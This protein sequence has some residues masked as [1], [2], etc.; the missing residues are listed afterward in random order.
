MSDNDERVLKV[1]V[2]TSSRRD[3]SSRNKTTT[4]TKKKEIIVD[5]PRDLDICCGRG[6]GFFSHPGNILFQESVRQNVERYRSAASKNLKSTVVAD[7][8]KDLLREGL[9]FIKRDLESGSWFV[10]SQACCHEKTGHAIRDHLIQMKRSAESAAMRATFEAPAVTTRS[11]KNHSSSSTS[12]ISPK[13]TATKKNGSGGDSKKAKHRIK[14][15]TTSG[16]SAKKADARKTARDSITRET[17]NQSSPELPETTVVSSF[18]LGLDVVSL[19][20]SSDDL[21]EYDLFD[22]LIHEEPPQLL[23]VELKSISSTSNNGLLTQTISSAGSRH[24]HH[25]YS[26][27]DVFPQHL[28]NDPFFCVSTQ[29]QEHHGGRR[30]QH[31]APGGMAST[32]MVDASAEHEMLNGFLTDVPDRSHFEM[33]P[34]VTVDRSVCQ[35]ERQERQHQ[36]IHLDSLGGRD[37]S[38]SLSIPFESQGDDFFGSASTQAYNN[39]IGHRDYRVCSDSTNN[40]AASLLPHDWL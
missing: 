14:K 28:Q 34:C 38:L 36:G 23:P 26:I 20:S 39:F 1:L 16:G 31:Q 9:R 7:I 30:R 21:Q 2:S 33:N 5:T 29:L 12:K 25:N 24:Q 27:Q 8:V 19:T 32:A 4:T 13:Q 11:K 40:P 17:P 37:L 35:G 6:K 15:K 22:D 3:D 18:F 10:L